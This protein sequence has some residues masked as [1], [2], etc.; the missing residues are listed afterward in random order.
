MCLECRNFLKGTRLC[1]NSGGNSFG[2][3]SGTG[4]SKGSDG[5]WGFA[6][7]RSSDWNWIVDGN[8]SSG[9]SIIIWAAWKMAVSLSWGSGNYP[10]RTLV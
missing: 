5:N 7:S 4:G 10:L 9:G 6:G 8:G 2:W 3:N 1:H